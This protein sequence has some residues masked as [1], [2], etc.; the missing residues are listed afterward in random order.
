[1]TIALRLSLPAG[2]LGADQSGADYHSWYLAL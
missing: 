2:P 1:M